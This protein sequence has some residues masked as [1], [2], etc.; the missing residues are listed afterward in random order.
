MLSC[1]EVLAKEGE[2]LSKEDLFSILWI[3]LNLQN[4]DDDAEIQSI[5]VKSFGKLC[6]FMVVF[7]SNHVYIL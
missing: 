3:A 6:V 7:V 5:Q 2:A 1:Y 4:V